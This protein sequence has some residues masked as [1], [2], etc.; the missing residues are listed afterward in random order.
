MSKQAAMF[1]AREA[2]LCTAEQPA[3]RTDGDIN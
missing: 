3:V 2:D 1:G